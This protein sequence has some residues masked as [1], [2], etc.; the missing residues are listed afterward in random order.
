[1][2]L[3]CGSIVFGSPT[4]RRRRTCW[5]GGAGFVTALLLLRSLPLHAATSKSPARPTPRLRKRRRVRL[6]SIS[7]LPTRRPEQQSARVLT[8]VIGGRREN[9]SGRDTLIYRPRCNFRRN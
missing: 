3:R 7:L 6:L 2:L 8:R 5:S 1:M 4:R 9:R